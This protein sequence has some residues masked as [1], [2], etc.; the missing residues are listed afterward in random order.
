MSKN[1]KKN[2]VH[3]IIPRSIWGS[4]EDINKVVMKDTEHVNLHRYFGNSSPVQQLCNVLWLNEQVLTYKF[5]QDLIKVLINNF[6]N[7]YIDSAQLNK[8]KWDIW[9]VFELS[10]LFNEDIPTHLK[11]IYGNSI[12]DEGVVWN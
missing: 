5:K 8:I 1:N 3:H 6:G 7:Y 2:S 11:K 9:A 12:E 10:V 4:N